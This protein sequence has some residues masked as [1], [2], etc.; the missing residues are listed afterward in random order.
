MLYTYT[1]LTVTSFG[2][3]QEYLLRNYMHSA[4]FYLLMTLGSCFFLAALYRM[5]EYRWAGH[6][7]GRPS[8]P[9]MN[10]LTSGFCR[11]SRRRLNWA[12][13]TST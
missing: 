7:C 6:G 2:I 11:C 12:P 5:T 10:L 4:L 8:T 1:F 9:L 13:S 3:F